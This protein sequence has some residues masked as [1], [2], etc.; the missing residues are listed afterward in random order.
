MTGRLVH[1]HIVED[2]APSPI[3]ATT[4]VN[5][6]SSPTSDNGA[7]I[8]PM[9]MSSA[10]STVSSRAGYEMGL[11]GSADAIN[12]SD[13]EE[14]TLKN[15]QL[16]ST[17]TLVGNVKHRPVFI[18]DDM[19]DKS[20]SWIA[21]AET[22]VKK[23]GATHVYCMATHGLF[24]DECLAEMEEC[25]CIHQIIVTNSFPIPVEKARESTKLQVLDVS[26]L[27]AESI[28]R[29][30]HGESISQLYMHSD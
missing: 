23:G 10:L 21:A 5:G 14:E 11:G 24:G 20:A 26:K 9:A 25:E 17:V 19:I 2:D 6:Q 4:S 12:S 28:R 7:P 3:T 27:L 8:D 13:D 22:V 30:H 18:M 1:G 15:P 16:E 29:N